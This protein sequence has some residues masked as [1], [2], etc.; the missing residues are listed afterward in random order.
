MTSEDT[1]FLARV[2]AVPRLRGF[3]GSV[4]DVPGDYAAWV[5]CVT[6]REVQEGTAFAPAQKVSFAI[7]SPAMLLGMGAEEAIG[8]TYWLRYSTVESSVG[9][10]PRLQ[11][12]LEMEHD[13]YP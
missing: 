1:L 6:V 8:R 2:D 12:E 5:L 11:W 3:E 13:W 7:H 4:I 10:I 9:P